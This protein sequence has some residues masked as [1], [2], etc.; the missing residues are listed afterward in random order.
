MRILENRQPLC[1]IVHEEGNVYAFAAQE[2]AKY[3][4]LM[5]R[6]TFLVA[7][8]E[9]ACLYI[10]SLPWCIDHMPHLAVGASPVYDGFVIASDGYQGM[11]AANEPRGVLY[12]VYRMLEEWGCTWA[13]PGIGGERI[14]ERLDL[15]WPDG[16]LVESPSFER[17]GIMYGGDCFPS[18]LFGWQAE[19]VIDW[20]EKNRLNCYFLHV[21]VKEP[22]NAD[23][24]AAYQAA[25]RSA[26][27]KRGMRLELG[28]HGFQHLVLPREEY[29]THPEWFI[30]KDGRRVK[31][32]N[33]CVSAEDMEERAYRAVCTLLEAYPQVESLHLYYDDVPGGSWCTC[34]KCRHMTAT[35]MSYAVHRAVAQRLHREGRSVEIV[36]CCYHDTLDTRSLEDAPPENLMFY[37]APRERCYRH[38]LNE[39]TCTRNTEYDDRIAELAYRWPQNTYAMEY[40]M[41]VI[42][43]SNMKTVLPTVIA[44]DLKRYYSLGIRKITSLDFGAYS[45]YAYDI[46]FAVFARLAWDVEADTES[47]FRQ[48]IAETYP[49]HTTEMERYYQE[50]ER[51]SGLW[52]SFC[53]YTATFDIRDCYT[54]KGHETFYR[55]H[56]AL[57]EQALEQTDH[58]IHLL[59]LLLQNAM[60]QEAL[61]LQVEKDVQTVTREELRAVYHRL[62]GILA[63]QL[64]KEYVAAEAH[65]QKTLQHKQREADMV[66][67]FLPTVVGCSGYGEN[68]ILI[69]HNCFDQSD[70]TRAHLKRI[71]EERVHGGTANELQWNA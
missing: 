15:N 14:P 53:G 68:S 64:D 35:Q 17:R 8:G 62:Q 51:A 26:V 29:K 5:S 33:F 38:A 18:A 67:T 65:I 66:R 32:G 23:C 43:F 36:Y 22:Y 24:Q 1:R 34:E 39:E 20:M 70:W 56:T 6:A 49:F 57:V 47:V 21:D 2:L 12:A 37:T 45:W 52:L 4:K 61:R 44:Q 40:Y 16:W 3:L 58:L 30:E 60:G 59:T 7:E 50:A 11:L 28:G 42:L 10:G 48:V 25:Y 27:E 71:E 46:N 19:E 69:R 54:A 13:L 41:D 55:H 31:E 63:Y 9:G